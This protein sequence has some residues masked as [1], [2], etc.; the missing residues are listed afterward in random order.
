MNEH[1]GQRRPQ[2][3]AVSMDGRRMQITYR[4]GDQEFVV[5]GVVLGIG[6]FTTIRLDSGLHKMIA[7]GTI[8]EIEECAV[9][10]VAPTLVGLGGVATQ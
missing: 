5:H 10:Y 1:N 8:F 2:P 4:R 6:N 7:T 3:Q 9:Q